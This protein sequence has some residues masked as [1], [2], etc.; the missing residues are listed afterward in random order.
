M[1]DLENPISPEAVE[2]KFSPDNLSD[3][4]TIKLTPEELKFYDY[5][6]ATGNATDAY[7]RTWPDDAITLRAAS[8]NNKA[9]KLVMKHNWTGLLKKQKPPVRTKKALEVGTPNK[10]IARGVHGDEM[11]LF[12]ARQYKAGALT[13][14]EL[15][16]QMY[17]LSREAIQ[18]SVRMAATDKLKSWYDLARADI[19]SSELSEQDIVT[20]LIG[21][22]SDLPREKYLAVLRG[23]RAKRLDLIGRR[24]EV[25]DV[26]AEVARFKAE[27]E[28]NVLEKG[29]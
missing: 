17:T 7:R 13:E 4:H 1:P 2:E 5:L 10:H 9:S 28:A 23:A 8:L 19:K 21:A 26:D 20:L 27:K 6:R 12:A 15:W 24:T 29:A 11:V 18:E 25:I 14:E 22:I 3:P 16:D